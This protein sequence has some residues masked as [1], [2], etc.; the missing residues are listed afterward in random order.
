MQLHITFPV[1]FIINLLSPPLNLFIKCHIY[2]QNWI[3]KWLF[4]FNLKNNTIV[5]K[6]ALLAG[7][8]ILK[9]DIQ[10]GHNQTII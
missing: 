8:P 6:L 2:K 5:H 9:W 3:F 7:L 4:K 10:T 1:D